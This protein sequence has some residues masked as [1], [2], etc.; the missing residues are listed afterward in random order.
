MNWH[1]ATQARLQFLLFYLSLRDYYSPINDFFI[2]IVEDE[3]EPLAKPSSAVIKY[4]LQPIIGPSWLKAS[5]MELYYNGW[6]LTILRSFNNSVNPI[7]YLVFYK[8]SQINH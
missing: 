4:E 3:D 8:I 2:I 7:V 1:L 5:E 6:T